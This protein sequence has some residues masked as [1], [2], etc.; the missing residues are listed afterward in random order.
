MKKKISGK[1]IG[2]YIGIVALLLGITIGAVNVGKKVKNGAKA[3]NV[4]ELPS[5][6]A[7][8]TDAKEVVTTEDTKETTVESATEEAVLEKPSTA[9]KSEYKEDKKDGKTSESGNVNEAK[10]STHQTSGNV[11]HT[12]NVN[13]ND[14]KPST[15]QTSG[16]VQPT[17]NGSTNNNGSNTNNSSV[18]PAQTSTTTTESAKEDTTPKACEHTWKEVTKS[19]WVKPVEHTEKVTTVIEEAKDVPIT[20]IQNHTFCSGCGNDLTAMGLSSVWDYNEH[21]EACQ[22]GNASYYWK[23]VTVITGYEHVPAK[24]VTETKT[25]VDKEGYYKEEVVGYECTKCGATK[26]K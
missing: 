3:G 13:A 25:V 10:P 11:Q 8:V 9:I 22:G 20:E 26:D 15:H 18:T 5:V 12:T 2:V 23:D 19:V 6:E 14:A 17:T 21:C 4:P 16:N 24:T 7:T 1:R